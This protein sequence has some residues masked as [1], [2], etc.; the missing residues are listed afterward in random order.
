MHIVFTV[1]SITSVCI[2]SLQCELAT[3]FN[4]SDS[5]MSVKTSLALSLWFLH[6][7]SIISFSKWKAKYLNLPLHSITSVCIL[8]LQCGQLH[9]YVYC[10]YSVVNYIC[11]HIVFTV[12]SITSK[13]LKVCKYQIFPSLLQNSMSVIATCQLKRL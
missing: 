5:H 11:M 10:L 7:I 3:K 2:L 13:R 12:W 4:V 9:L 6:D 8:S 1:W